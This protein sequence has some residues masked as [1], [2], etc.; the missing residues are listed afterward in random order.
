MRYVF[1]GNPAV[2]KLRIRGFASPD[3]SGFAL[4]VD[5]YSLNI[6]KLEWYPDSIKRSSTKK[7]KTNSYSRSLSGYYPLLSVFSDFSVFY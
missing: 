4:S 7:M 5:S 2:L 3:H 1:F 6:F